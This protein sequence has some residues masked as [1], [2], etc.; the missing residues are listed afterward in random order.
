MNKKLMQIKLIIMDVDGVLT[1]GRIILG[2]EE[3]LKF[4]H[5]RDG[6]GISIARASGLKIGVIT[7]RSSIA[8][9]RRAKE[10][11]IDYIVQGCKNK[12]KA[13]DEILEKEKINYENVCYIGDDIIDI[14][15]FRLVGYSATVADAP[16][17]IK[18]ETAYVSNK[19][20]G[21]GAVRDIIEFILKNKGN[22]ENTI[23][24]M[25][26]EWAND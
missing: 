2:K 23:N 24:N 8:V 7:G 1:D 16:E 6:M 17:S 26:K 5:V 4:F 3:E 22:L 9:E 14:P 15:V 11:K 19:S 20:G 12:L 21:K 25:I 18:S 10:L 13:L